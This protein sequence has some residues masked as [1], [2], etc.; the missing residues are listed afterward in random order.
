MPHYPFEHFQR[1]HFQGQKSGEIIL[2]VIRRH[3]FNIAQQMFFIFLLVVILLGASLFLPLLLPAL[4]NNLWRPVI[5][6]VENALLLGIWFVFFLT[7]VD[8][9]FDTWIITNERIVA[10]YQNGL[11]SREVSELRFER[12]QDVSTDVVGIIPTVLNYGDILIQT[13]GEEEKFVFKNVPDPYTIK[14]LIMNIQKEKRRE[15][16]N[17]LG[18][19]IEEKINHHETT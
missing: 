13:A 4:N 2:M 10:I 5:S 18:E 1:F 6:L 15:D 7:W 9:Y 16:T 14:S 8:Y 17:E 12:I 19:M 11:F 3:W